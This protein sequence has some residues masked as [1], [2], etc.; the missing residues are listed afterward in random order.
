MKH[1]YFV[2]HGE[3]VLNVEGRFAGQIETELT[4]KGKE[5]AK[6]TGQDM[7]QQGIKV[8]VIVSSP[9]SRAHDTAKIIAEQIG[10]PIDQIKTNA[11]FMERSFGIL[12]DTS[13][14]GF[15]QV[16]AY[17][18]MDNMP[19]AETFE[20]VYNR[21]LKAHKYIESLN[22]ETVLVV[23]H[24]AFGRAYR[25]AMLGEPHTQEYVN[26]FVSMKNAELFKFL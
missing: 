18:D 3:T 26:P 22:A 16:Y 4:E 13:Y 24:G 6:A 8:D 23:S 12:E 19:G 5:Q 11:L 17:R 25:R 2:R 14:D 15:Y 7:K 21:T 9:L 1:L 10:Y 20:Q